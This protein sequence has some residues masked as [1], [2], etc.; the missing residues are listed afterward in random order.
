MGDLQQLR[1]YL[2]AQLGEIDQD[3]ETVGQMLGWSTCTAQLRRTVKRRQAFL[4]GRRTTVEGLLAGLQ[5]PPSPD[6]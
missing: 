5:P 4:R 2:E 1:R 3:L 6:Q